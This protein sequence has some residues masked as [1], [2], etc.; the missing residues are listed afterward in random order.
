VSTL[1]LRVSI[2]KGAINACVKRQKELEMIKKNATPGPIRLT[3]N[4]I[5]MERDVRIVDQERQQARAAG[6]GSLVEKA[7][8]QQIK[9]S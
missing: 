2:V 3:E 6:I 7:I 5:E 1:S 9:K 8:M 4:K